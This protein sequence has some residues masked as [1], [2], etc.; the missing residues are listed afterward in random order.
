MFNEHEIYTQTTWRCRLVA[1]QHIPMDINNDVIGMNIHS[2][3]RNDFKWEG[4]IYPD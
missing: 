1:N 2:Q 3:H 4:D